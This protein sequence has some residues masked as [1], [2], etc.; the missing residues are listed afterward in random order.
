MGGY[1]A[2]RNGLLNHD[3]FSHIVALSVADVAVDAIIDESDNAPFFQKRPYMEGI[4]GDLSKVKGSDKDIQWIAGELAG[5]KGSLPAIYLACGTEDELLDRNHRL[6]NCFE[7]HGYRLTYVEGPGKH[8]WDFWDAQI[9]QAIEW[10][11]LSGNAGMN[12]GNVF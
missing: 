2:L 7:K 11:P 12:S 3:I 9:R 8:E 6:K 1:G 5:K 4:F 10:L